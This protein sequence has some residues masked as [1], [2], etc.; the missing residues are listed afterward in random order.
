MIEIALLAFLQVAEPVVQETRSCDE[1]L[2]VCEP[3]PPTRL[4]QSTE[5]ACGDNVVRITGYGVTYPKSNWPAVDLNGQPLVG[6]ERMESDLR[7]QP[8][9]VFR[10]YGVCP[11]QSTDI[12]L[13]MYYAAGLEDGSVYVQAA[14][15]VIR[16][17]K[18]VEYTPFVDVS[19]ESF[20]YH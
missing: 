7:G 13:Y 11:Q 20:W 18:L 5:I 4:I 3:K 8:G 10:I 19:Y 14:S 17:E 12:L 6:R 2:V 9:G 15:G 16:D 1:L